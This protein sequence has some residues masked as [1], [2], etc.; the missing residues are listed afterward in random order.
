VVPADSYE[1]ST[2]V[3]DERSITSEEEP[4]D[5]R[6]VATLA[7]N[8]KD[9]TQTKGAV[10]IHLNKISWMATSL[11]QGGYEFVCSDAHGVRQC[12]RWVLRAKTNRRHSGSGGSTAPAGNDEKRFIFSVID[13]RTRRH[14]VI[15][16][17]SKNG[18]DILDEYSEST[19]TN[20]MAPSPETRESQQEKA[21]LKPV[22]EQL[23]TLIL[24]TGIWIAFR[25][26][27]SENLLSGEGQGSPVAHSQPEAPAQRG[28]N[29]T[30]KNAAGENPLATEAG[31]SGTKR[32][33][34]SQPL[35]SRRG[36]RLSPPT[37][38][39]K[40][41]KSTD[42]MDS[43][44]STPQPASEQ[45]NHRPNQNGKG[46]GRMEEPRTPKKKRPRGT[47]CSWFEMRRKKI[48]VE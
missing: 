22:D 42:D 48:P 26:G 7:H 21:P 35:A 6:E 44:I 16:W 46:N 10:T 29:A 32:L 27:W 9:D 4:S 15:A 12:V 30:G 23:S 33:V 39:K 24:T 47:L 40:D 11:A 8:R 5:Q 1:P 34:K 36:K 2:V 37:K 43:N 41:Q 14:P 38:T 13:P 45:A 19:P 17:M 20:E 28:S 25:E 18:I 3:D 31:E